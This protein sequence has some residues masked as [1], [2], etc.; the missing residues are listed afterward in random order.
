M[1][2]ICLKTN[3]AKAEY[4]IRQHQ[5]KTAIA[6]LKT[7]QPLTA[8]DVTELEDIL[9]KEIGTKKDY[10]NEVGTK[11]LVNLSVKLSDWI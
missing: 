11:P 5:D 7:N 10:E 1:K 8:P 3:K 2:V 4:Y 9:W 6:K